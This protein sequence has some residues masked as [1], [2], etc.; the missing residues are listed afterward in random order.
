M[1]EVLVLI[2]N[3]QKLASVLKI[4]SMKVAANRMGTLPS[5]SES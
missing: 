3:Q 5:M 2:L 4:A 1:N